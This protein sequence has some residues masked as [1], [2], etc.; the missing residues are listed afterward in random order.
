MPFILH[1]EQGE[2]KALYSCL[3][4]VFESESKQSC[5][6]KLRRKDRSHL[7]VLL[8]SIASEHDD[9]IQCLNA[10]MDVARLRRSEKET[11]QLMPELNRSNEDL[12]RFASV[13][14]HDLQE[15][16]QVIKGF[17]ALLERRYKG[18]LD[19]KVMN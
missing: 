2:M 12:Q 16:L 1:L 4:K 14:S 9:G 13:L 8:E 18:R 11:K 3:E 7:N 5:K 17:L 15:P 19:E 6:L 10:I